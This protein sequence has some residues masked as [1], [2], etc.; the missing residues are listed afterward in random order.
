MASKKKEGEPQRTHPVAIE[1]LKRL[2]VA[3]HWARRRVLPLHPQLCGN[4][5]DPR[6]CCVT[7][8]ALCAADM[9]ALYQALLL[10]LL[11]L[12]QLVV[13]LE[14]LLASYSFFRPL[15]SHVGVEEHLSPVLRHQVGEREPRAIVEVLRTQLRKQT[16]D[17]IFFL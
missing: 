10:L 11:E 16:D 15:F 7:V 17:G 12:V 13:C 8:K 4:P 3:Q 6:P 2:R 14:D 1:R 5:L 9:P